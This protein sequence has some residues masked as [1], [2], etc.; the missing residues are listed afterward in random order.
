MSFWWW[1]NRPIRVNFSILEELEKEKQDVILVCEESKF[2]YLWHT[3]N[4]RKQKQFSD[5]QQK[6]HVYL[7]EKTEN[8]EVLS[9]KFPIELLEYHQPETLENNR[10]GLKAV[11]QSWFL[12]PDSQ[13]TGEVPE[14][15][16][17]ISYLVG[18]KKVTW[19]PIDFSGFIKTKDFWQIWPHFFSKNSV[20]VGNPFP[21]DWI[22][23]SGDWE[24]LKTQMRDLER[25]GGALIK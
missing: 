19:V 8:W 4:S 10:E 7:H 5:Q 6:Q 21:V 14:I 22:R 23:E 12:I 16:P 20:V 15:K 24:F 2:L 17:V 18:K 11:Q 1:S 3:L 9:D 13:Q 25:L